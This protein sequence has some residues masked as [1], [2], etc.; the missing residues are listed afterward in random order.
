M[1]DQKTYIVRVAVSVSENE[2]GPALF[3]KEQRQSIQGD[4]KSAANLT[5]TLGYETVDHIAQ[6]V[7]AR[8]VLEEKEAKA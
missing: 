1:S 6:A 3:V 5:N 7:G 8:H 2:Y 4:L